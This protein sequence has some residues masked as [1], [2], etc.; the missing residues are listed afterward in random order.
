MIIDHETFSLSPH[1]SKAPGFAPPFIACE[2]VNGCGKSTLIKNL[3]L[4]LEGAGRPYVTTR[5]PGGTPLGQELRKL[6]L[7]WKGEKKSDLAELLLFAADRAEHAD[8][9]IRPALAAGKTVL[10]DRYLYSTITFQGNGRGISMDW[11][12]Q[13]NALA[14]QG[15]LP[16]LVILMD[17]DPSEGLRRTKARSGQGEDAFEA[18]ELAFHHRIREGFL[19][20]ARESPVPFLVLNGLDSKEVNLAKAAKVLS[21]S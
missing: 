14:T 15:L 13:T 1:Y 5:E 8:K 4:Q 3:A 18:E 19:I 2:G 10:C 6:L 16:D 21:I 9:I 17:V 12:Q 20:L 11:I 7:E